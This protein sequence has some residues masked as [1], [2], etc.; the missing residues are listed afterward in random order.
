[1]GSLRT[2]SANLSRGARGD[3]RR[4]ASDEVGNNGVEVKGAPL[5]AGACSRA[6]VLWRGLLLSCE[7]A[8][9]RPVEGAPLVLFLS[10]VGNKGVKVKGL[11]WPQ[12]EG[13]GLLSSCLHWVHCIS[14]VYRISLAHHWPILSLSLPR[15]YCTAAPSYK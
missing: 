15:P 5:R 11:P 8:C 10:W 7:G 2:S 1:M 3:G 4:A 14:I 13:R 6:L 9:S 12:V